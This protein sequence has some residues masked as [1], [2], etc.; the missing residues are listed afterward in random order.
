MLTVKFIENRNLRLKA[1]LLFKLLLMTY[2][3]LGVCNLTYGSQVI[4]AVMYPTFLLGG[5]LILWRLVLAK[6]FMRQP[7]LYLLVVL[8]LSFVFSAAAN[9]KYVNSAE[10][11]TFV[12]WC[13]Y[14]LLLFARDSQSSF[15]E[16]QKEINIFS[17]FYLVYVTVLVLISYYMLF[18]GYSH[19]YR[20][21]DNGKYEVASGIFTG[22]LWGAFQDPNL[23]SVMCCIAI[24]V[25][26]YIM[27]SKK[28]AVLN[29]LL[30][31]NSVLMFF[32]IVLS[33]SR[34]GMVTLGCVLGAAVFFVGLKR[35][36]GVKKPGVNFKR[37]LCVVL[38]AVGFLAGFML[39]KYAQKAYNTVASDMGM[40]VVERDYDVSDD[41]SNRRLD[42]WKSGVEIALS[43]PVTGVSFVGLVPYAKDNM[44]D[45]YIVNNDL[46]EFNT[47]DNDYLN[48]FAAQGLIG[49]ITVLALMALSVIKIFRNIWKSSDKAFPLICLSAVSVCSL[50]ISALFQ[51]TMFYQQTPNTFMFWL[52]L[53]SILC[54]LPHAAEVE[55]K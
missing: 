26:V 51:G 14:F 46:W 38:A 5:L 36:A 53:G 1:E 24:A 32:Y 41:V 39:P 19:S 7:E 9:F 35:Y 23:G 18:T 21:P 54:V 22:R 2:T 49:I 16:I 17:V 4:R 3:M 31:I 11:A 55:E 12:L 50:A 44:P 25:S 30:T 45:T 20:D 47:L 8:L 43:R 28:K 37:A 40:L 15:S 27:Y 10:A 52:M 13:F 29:V 42:V 6:H 48:V 34:N 33:D